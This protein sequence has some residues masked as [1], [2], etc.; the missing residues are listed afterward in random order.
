MARCLEAKMS[1][2]SLAIYPHNGL[3]GRGSACEC[4]RIDMPKSL[5]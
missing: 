2:V 4:P 5:L 1:S 3:K